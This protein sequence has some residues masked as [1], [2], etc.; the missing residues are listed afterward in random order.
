MIAVQPGALRTVLRGGTV[1][2]GSGGPPRLADVEIHGDRIT[3][4]GSV[5]DGPGEVIDATGMLVTPGFIDVHTHYDGQVTWA[6]QLLPSS[7]HGVTTAIIGN[8]GVGFAPCR[9]QDRDTLVRLMEGVEDIPEIVFTQG[10]P[11]A[12]ETFPQY[13]DFLAGREFDM[14][15]GAYLPHAALRVYAMGQRGARREPATA[16]D[17]Q[18]M[19]ELACEA[20]RVGAFGFSTSRTINHRSSDGSNTPMYQAATEELVEIARGLQDAGSGLLQVVAGFTQPVEDFEVLRAMVRASNRPLSVSLAQSHERPDDWQ[21]ILRMMESASSQGLDITAQVCAR[22]VGMLM[23]LDMSLHPFSFHPAYRAIAHLPLAERVA[24]MR[25]P[26]VRELILSQ[27]PDASLAGDQRSMKRAL[28]LEGVYPLGDPTDY[29]PQAGDSIA[30]RARALAMPPQQLAY[31]MLL[32]DEGHLVLMRPVHSYAHHDLE[33]C[34]EML[35]H[36]LT[37]IGLGDGGAHCGYICDASWPTFML[38]HWTRDRTRGPRMALESAVK[39]QSA[40]P[41]RLMGLHDR[42]LVAP[43]RKADLN[44]IDYARLRLQSPRVVYDLPGQGRRLLQDAQGY[45]A[46]IVSGQVTRRNGQ[47]TSNLPG[48]LLRAGTA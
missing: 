17:R 8:C 44:V 12:W 2:D 11:W 21:G 41:A 1:V 29:E 15:V 16:Q 13:L 45:V 46:T 22:A 14:D 5:P 34:R 31:D 33:A 23:G 7:A 37:V 9:S 24:Q 4:V 47:A 26:E 48:R 42:G 10:L 28:D 30:A 25:R 18:R 6:Q 40:D 19:R 43:G 39:M 32:R 20:M 3:A 27:Q 36:P 35:Q 38:T